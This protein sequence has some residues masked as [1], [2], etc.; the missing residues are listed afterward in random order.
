MR[1]VEILAAAAAVCV[2]LAGPTPAG[3]LEWHGHRH[4]TRTVGFAGSAE[5]FDC[6][7]LR[8]EFEDAEPLRAEQDLTIPAAGVLRVRTAEN[9]GVRVLGGDRTDY[10]VKLCKAA[11][12]S[13]ALGEI[14]AVVSG[15]ELSVSGPSLDGDWIG[16]LLIEA[17]RGA[18]MDLVA[19]NGP[20]GVTGLAG[21]LTAESTNGPVSLKKCA[22]EVHARVQNGPISISGSGG[23]FDLEAQNGPIS[24]ALAST[25]WDGKLVARAVNGPLSIKVPDGFRSGMRVSASGSSLMHCSDDAC[26]NARRSWDDEGKFIEFGQAAPVVL[27]STVNGPVSVR[28]WV[29]R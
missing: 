28:S 7:R 12:E 20:I 24:V 16:Y 14:H 13:G 10:A 5:A 2:F 4:Q 22:G 29:P 27:L 18:E 15:R 1:N 6:S 23:Q 8:V 21:R 3:A 17:P 26:R 25:T 11:P 19:V 9:S